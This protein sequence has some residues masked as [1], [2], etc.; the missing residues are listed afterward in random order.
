MKDTFKIRY[1]VYNL[2]SEKQ[3]KLTTTFNFFVVF[4]IT[5]SSLVLA[6]F[7]QWFFAPKQLGLFE[8]LLELNCLCT[9]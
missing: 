7:L 6:K 5:R 1:S 3:L 4:T 2:H 9:S 8:I